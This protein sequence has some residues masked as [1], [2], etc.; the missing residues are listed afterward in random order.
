[1]WS[2]CWYFNSS[3]DGQYDDLLYYFAYQYEVV[4]QAM[5]ERDA[6]A[7]QKRL[8]D[9]D[10]DDQD[11]DI[12]RQRKKCKNWLDVFVLFFLLFCTNHTSMGNYSP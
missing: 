5:I 4:R 9:D 6:A 3:Y 12:H 10:G 1:M 2:L 11:P 8:A 7:A